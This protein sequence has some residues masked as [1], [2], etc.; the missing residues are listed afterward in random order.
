MSVTDWRKSIGMQHY[1]IEITDLAEHYKFIMRYK[2][3]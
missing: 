1:E 3:K 2:G